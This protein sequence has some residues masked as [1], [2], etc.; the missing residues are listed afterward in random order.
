MHFRVRIGLILF[1]FVSLQLT[2]WF[3]KRLALEFLLFKLDLL[4]QHYFFFLLFFNNLTILL[5]Y[6]L[7]VLKGVVKV[8]FRG[9]W[10]WNVILRVFELVDQLYI[11]IRSQ[12][13][14][15]PGLWLRTL[16]LQSLVFFV[17]LRRA[18][19]RGG[20]A[21]SLIYSF[22]LNGLLLCYGSLRR[23]R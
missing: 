7:A 8:N 16:H 22:L 11:R 12:V 9:L 3:Y 15:C 20:F 18:C 4:G 2:M 13:R 17:L 21:L 6:E 14:A 10:L 1:I 19:D 5:V 23:D